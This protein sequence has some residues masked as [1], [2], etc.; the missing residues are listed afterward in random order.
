RRCAL[1]IVAA[2]AVA[3]AALLAAVF[4]VSSWRDRLAQQQAEQ[5][6]AVR[7]RAAEQSIDEFLAARRT[8]DAAAVLETFVAMP[9]HRH[10]R[11]RTEALRGWGERMRVR[12]DIAAAR[13][14][15]ARAYTAAQDLAAER[16]VLGDLVHLFHE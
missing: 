8:A 6:A 10:T 7:L 14:A 16:A 4:W 11:A 5:L 3:L 9:E 12:G 1:A 13:S 15:H 2:A